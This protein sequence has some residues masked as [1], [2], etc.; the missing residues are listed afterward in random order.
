M[1]LRTKAN[2]LSGLAVAAIAAV[3]ALSPAG[4]EGRPQAAGAK[5]AQEMAQAATNFL[6]SLSPEQRAKAEF[7]FKDDERLNWHFIPK[8]RK[9]IPLKDLPP[10]ARQLALALLSTGLSQRGY[11]KAVT[12]MSL[13][14]VLAELE[15]PNRRIP[16][17]P[18]LYHVWVFGKPGGKD[19]WGWRVE[20]HH[21][22]VN[23]TVA[24]DRVLASSPSFLGANPQKVLDGPRKGLRALAAEE[25]LA[26]K[27]VKSLTEDQRKEAVI[28]AEAPRDIVTA[29]ARKVSPLSPAGLAAAKL[30]KDQAEALR[31]LVREYAFRHRPEVAEEDL[32]RI[33]KAGFEKVHFAWAGGLEPGQGH[34]YRV[35]GPTFLIEFDNTQ[36]NA[37]HSH[38]VWRDFANDFGEDLL[39]KHYEERR[40]DK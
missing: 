5:A 2:L 24:G 13:E 32:G 10:A 36:N 4:S 1:P 19:P 20:G 22:S 25:D 12:I 29:A 28:L 9:G 35:Q 26:R 3:I 34:Y 18:D 39:R 14:A 38:T 37:N 17:D 7:A 31:T 30:Q 6:S 33:D 15:G 8:E 11:E 40:H 23:F 21:V 27:L 16:R